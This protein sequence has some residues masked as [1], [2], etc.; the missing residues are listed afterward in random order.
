MTRGND[1][2]TMMPR[3]PALSPM[4][5]WPRQGPGGTRRGSGHRLG[6]RVALYSHD[7]QGL[8]HVRRNSLLAA[9]MVA[10]D[11]AVRILLVSGAREAAA[12]PLPDRT[13]LTI[14]PELAKDEDGG[15]SAR[16]S[17]CSLDHVVALRS[18]ALEHALAT[19][20]PNLLVVDK[21]ARGF[22]G[23]LEPALQLLRRHHGTR[24]VLGLR[25]VLDD[26]ATTRDEW[27]QSRTPDAI[28][29]LYDQV[30]VYGDP[31]LFDPAVAYGW[32]AAVREKVRYTGYLAAGRELL[33]PGRASSS[34]DSS[35]APTAGAARQ[36]PYVL[37]LLGG[38]QDGAAVADAF[39]RAVFPPGHQGVLV[40][41][42]YLPVSDLDRLGQMARRRGDLRVH[43]FVSDV[44]ALVRAAAATISMGGYN[45][46]CEILAA[47]RP[48][49]VVPRTAPRREQAIRA[50]CFKKYG[51]LDVLS[52]A[53]LGP[54]PL[55]RWLADALDRPDRPL[56][57][58]DLGGLGTV[59][60]LVTALLGADAERGFRDVG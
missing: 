16:A 25:D 34:S 2:L 45:S 44:P 24:I 52:L 12:L 23:E 56:R 49:L 42:P 36:T 41:G 3:D 27:E 4:G 37:A 1:G 17:T 47:R 21:V 11:P 39:A 59:P 8:G 55:T 18:A 57:A 29:T 35:A 54:A 30:W 48:A 60:G 10:A 9:A 33:L 5:V 6:R 19:Y 31:V 15:Y 26:V 14:V 20:Q 43:R 38:G 13:D 40:T 46:V 7:T 50:E 53:D 22:G 51:L 32:S 58:I 28:A